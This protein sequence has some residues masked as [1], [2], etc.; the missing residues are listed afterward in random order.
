MRVA[1]QVLSR[2]FPNVDSVID[3]KVT[4]IGPE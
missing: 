3:S 2:R 4:G 1:G